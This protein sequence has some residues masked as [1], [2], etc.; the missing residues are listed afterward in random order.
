MKPSEI[1]TDRAVQM[2]GPDGEPMVLF[3]NVL[4]ATSSGKIELRSET[5]AKRWGAAAL[6][7]DWREREVSYPLLLISPASDKRISSTLGGLAPSHH[8]PTLLMNPR[9]AAQRDV[10]DGTEVR[11]WNERGE[12]ILPAIV[13]AA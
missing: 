7:P 12:V 11:L 3:D 6:L 4:P 9:D 13:T 5:L 2:T 8:P 10:Q 1:P